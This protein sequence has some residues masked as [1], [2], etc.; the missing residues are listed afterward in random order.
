MGRGKT[1]KTRTRTRTRPGR[2]IPFHSLWPRGRIRPA[3]P[4]R[5]AKRNLHKMLATCKLHVSPSFPC[6]HCMCVYVGVVSVCYHPS[7]NQTHFAALPR[8]LSAIVVC[9][10]CMCMWLLAFVL[11]V[12]ACAC[13]CPC[14]PAHGPLVYAA[15]LSSIASYACCPSPDVVLFRLLHA[16]QFRLCPLAY[17]PVPCRVRLVTRQACSLGLACLPVCLSAAQSPRVSSGLADLGS[18]LPCLPRLPPRVAVMWCC[19]HWCTCAVASVGPGVD[20]QQGWVMD[21]RAWLMVADE[22]LQGC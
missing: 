4:M 7:N 15:G 9:D 11:H 8:R 14:P 2:R 20:G 17:V 21:E 1:G 5:P 22:W 3:P 19:A 18:C 6:F 10:L 13:V 16:P 12:C